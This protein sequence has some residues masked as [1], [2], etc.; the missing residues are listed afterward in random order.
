MQMPATSSTH[1]AGEM[2]VILASGAS[3]GTPAQAIDRPVR[4]GGWQASWLRSEVICV[5]CATPK[6]ASGCGSSADLLSCLKQS[7]TVSE[8]ALGMSMAVLA[9]FG[10]SFFVALGIVLS[11]QISGHP[12]GAAL[13]AVPIAMAIFIAVAW[14]W[15]FSMSF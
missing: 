13:G 8:R 2:R 3:D 9:A 6:R 5:F 11:T 7:A 12:L 1:G 15:A 4:C 10:A 14:L